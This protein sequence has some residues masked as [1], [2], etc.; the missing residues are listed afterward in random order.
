[1]ALGDREGQLGLALTEQNH[2]KTGRISRK[3]LQ[4]VATLI[5]CGIVAT[6]QLIISSDVIYWIR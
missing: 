4:R 3:A 2:T 5:V 1:L 6:M